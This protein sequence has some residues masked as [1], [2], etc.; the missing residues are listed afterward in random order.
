MLAMGDARAQIV[1]HCDGPYEQRE[2]GHSL[3]YV[4]RRPST[5]AALAAAAPETEP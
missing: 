4:C 5:T 1:D 3:I 2:L